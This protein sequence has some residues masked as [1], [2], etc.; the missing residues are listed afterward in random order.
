[1]PD[2]TDPKIVQQVKLISILAPGNGFTAAELAEQLG[3]ST[4]SIYR[5][6]DNL[7][8][9][10][11]PVVYHSGRYSFATEKTKDLSKVMYFTTEEA[12]VLSEALNNIHDDTLFKANL[13]SKLG[14]FID[15]LSLPKCTIKY[16]NASNV[17][18]VS[19]AIKEHRQ[20]VFHDYAS[21]NS[22]SVRDRYVEPF[23]F[24]TNYAEIWCYD[25]EDGKNKTFKT[26]RISN[27]EVLPVPWE[28][29][30]AHR[31]GFV[32]VFRMTGYERYRVRLRLGVRAYSLLIEEFPMAEDNIFEVDETHWFLDTL[33]A[34]YRGV[35]RF[36][37]GLADDIDIIDTPELV[38]YIKDFTNKHVLPVIEGESVPLRGGGRQA[39]G[40]NSQL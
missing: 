34:N 33:V 31:K 29:G 5:Y 14:A 40:V 37:I 2:K 12:H 15:M 23:G 28:H 21:T 32:D 9:G 16:K 22:A 4:T 7:K 39:G 18:A 1:M 3:V 20:I 38:E 25:L 19:K 24:T 30:H 17:R 10:G 36:V 13:R 35:G 27:A 8:K 26:A 6:L 11:L